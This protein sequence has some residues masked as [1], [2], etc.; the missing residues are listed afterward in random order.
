MKRLILFAAGLLVAGAGLAQEC[1]VTPE[2]MVIGPASVPTWMQ[3]YFGAMGSNAWG[4]TGV[5]HVA[6]YKWTNGLA[7]AITATNYPTTAESL[8]ETAKRRDLLF[9]VIARLGEQGEICE[10]FGHQWRDGRPG[11]DDGRSYLDFHPGT[12]YRTCMVCGKCESRSLT[13]WR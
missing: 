10:V 13:D 9:A 1:V 8:I 7:R 11:E 12:F 2:N 3:E 5:A 6:E 4:C